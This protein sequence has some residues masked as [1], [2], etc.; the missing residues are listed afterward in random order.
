MVRLLLWVV[1]LGCVLEDYIVCFTDILIKKNKGS[2]PRH[3]EVPRQ[4]V[5]WE[6]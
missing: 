1:T 4:G 6:L 3:M 2:Y 5:K